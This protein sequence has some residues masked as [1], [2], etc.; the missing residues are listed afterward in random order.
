M[1]FVQ[2]IRDPDVVEAIRDFLWLRGERDYI[3]FSLGVFSGL[4]VSDMLGLRVHKVRGSHVNIIE[5]K[6]GKRK[7]F[8]IH[9]EIREDL[10]A[11]IADMDDDDFLFPSRQKKGNGLRGRPIDRSMAYKMLNKA[12]EQ[13]GLKEIGCHTMRKT[14]GYRLYTEDPANLALLM[15]MFNH[16]DQWTTL[17]YLGLTQDAMDRAIKRMS[18]AKKTS[19][20]NSIRRPANRRQ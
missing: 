3:F 11:Y 7:Q 8:V 17:R 10:N 4:R 20:S 19:K 18:Y 16:R 9:P 15:H 6:T 1:N 14:W 5:G 13:F 2:P 12:A